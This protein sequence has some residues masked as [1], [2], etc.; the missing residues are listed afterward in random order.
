MILWDLS[1]LILVFLSS[2]YP[3]NNLCLVQKYTL[4]SSYLP[5]LLDSKKILGVAKYCM[6]IPFLSGL[7]DFFPLKIWPYFLQ[8]CSKN[9]FF[10]WLC[11]GN[12]IHY[13]CKK[14]RTAF[15][16]NF[17]CIFICAVIGHLI[18]F[19]TVKTNDVGY[20]FFILKKPSIIL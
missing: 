12:I 16:I 17:K 2:F 15:F 10:T 3:E 4:N 18:K 14:N 1:S 8:L 13:Y 7:L 5:V 11:Y 6:N 20:Y 19:L 9:W